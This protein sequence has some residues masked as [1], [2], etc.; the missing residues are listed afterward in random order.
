VHTVR[1]KKK[2]TNLALSKM[3]YEREFAK[4]PGG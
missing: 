3:D 1:L 4:A 2:K